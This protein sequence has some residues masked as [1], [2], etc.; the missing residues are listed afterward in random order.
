MSD[1]VV[2][3][4]NHL[5]PQCATPGSAGYDL[6]ANVDVALAPGRWAQVGTGLYLELPSGYV[7]Q[8]CP[9]SGLALKHGISILNAP[10]IIDSDYR[11]E[12]KILLVNH[13]ALRYNVKNGDKIAQLVFVPVVHVQM[14]H[15][16]QLTETDRAEGGF[17]STGR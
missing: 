16:D 11:G 14:K 5:A 10:G 13:G 4:K 1:I 15:I 3:Y 6:I 7:A 12:I 2:G 9:R 8:V 17:G